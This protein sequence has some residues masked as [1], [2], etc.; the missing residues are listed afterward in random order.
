MIFSRYQAICSL[1]KCVGMGFAKHYYMNK[2]VHK[3]CHFKPQTSMLSWGVQFKLVYAFSKD[4]VTWNLYRT[5]VWPL[6]RLRLRWEQ[7]YAST[8]SF[9]VL[10]WLFHLEESLSTLETLSWMWTPEK[11]DQSQLVITQIIH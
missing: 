4:S 1:G 7:F 11:Y 10:F 6:K 5:L 8:F 3:M 2:W 9:A